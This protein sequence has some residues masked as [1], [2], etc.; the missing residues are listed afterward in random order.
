M[1]LGHLAFQNE[2]K[3]VVV[4]E[5][6]HFDKTFQEMIRY[7]P[8]VSG[9]KNGPYF[10]LFWGWRFTYISLIIRWYV[11]PFEVSEMFGEFPWDIF[12]LVV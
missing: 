5:S 11:P 6:S 4:R 2:W 3:R 10:T 1:E 8:K 7:S 12:H 9:T